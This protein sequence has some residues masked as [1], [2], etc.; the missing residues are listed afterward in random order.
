MI[1]HNVFHG[2]NTMAKML[3]R[4]KC[5]KAKAPSPN[6][7]SQISPVEYATT[8][9][10]IRDFD[11]YVKDKP[12]VNAYIA[13]VNRDPA[14]ATRTLQGTAGADL[15]QKMRASN[16]NPN[17]GM[18]SFTKGAVLGGKVMGDLGR[19]AVS[20][21]AASVNGV[22]QSKLG[23]Q[24]NVNTAQ[25][26]LAADA[27]KRNIDDSAFEYGKQGSTMSSA[28]SLLGAGSS[29]FYNKKNEKVV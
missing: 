19:D 14:I 4:S 2:W 25:E 20:Q 18:P 13:D 26:G 16:I 22:L 9:R 8:R 21:K 27:V 28:A 23:L 6:D 11:Q 29:M 15:A 24:S 17:M 7:T 12:M 3:V 1:Y 5:Y 10:S